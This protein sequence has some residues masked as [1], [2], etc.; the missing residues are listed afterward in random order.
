[1]ALIRIDHLPETIKMNLPLDLLVPEPGSMHGLPVRDRKVLYLLHGLSDDASAWQRYTT[2]ELLAAAYGLVV[3]M[4]SVGH[5]FYVDQ[6]NGQAYFSYLVDEL[7]RYLADVFDLQPRRENTLIAGCS[8]GGYGAMKAAFLRPAQYA[9]A[10]SLSGLLS[11][12]FMRL[13]PDDPRM[14]EFAYLFGDLRQ[15]SGSMHDPLTWI[16]HAAAHVA[17]LPRL[18]LACGRQDDLYP[19]NLIFSAA[20]QAQ[21]IPLNYY[22]EDARHEWSF[23]DQQIRRF[24][25]EALGEPV[26]I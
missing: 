3:V 22:E 9:S 18:Y 13:H 5:S 20:C 8:M 25:L 17:D 4:P 12:E 24:L 23:W 7:P 10:A 11:L 21:G 14:P 6:P 15:L 16:N 2:I 1:M 19:L 26:G